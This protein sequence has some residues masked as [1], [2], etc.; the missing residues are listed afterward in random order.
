MNIVPFLYTVFCVLVFYNHKI[1]FVFQSFR[2][3]NSTVRFRV[4]LQSL[5]Y[6]LI[7]ESTS[8]S[9][10]TLISN[11]GGNLGLFVGM[12]IVSMV[13]LMVF[14]IDLT[15]QSLKKK[16]KIQEQKNQENHVKWTPVY[17]IPQSTFKGMG[18]VHSNVKTAWSEEK[19][20]KARNYFSKIFYDEE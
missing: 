19:K 12:S 15:S 8:Y 14:I 13:E 6:E 16:Q 1:C 2:S 4:Y 5:K 7:K 3:T 10:D 18:E 17:V 20:E 11:L 9:F